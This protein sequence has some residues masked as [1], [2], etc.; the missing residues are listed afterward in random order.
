MSVESYFYPQPSLNRRRVAVPAVPLDVV[1][2]STPVAVPAV[3]AAAADQPGGG[4]RHGRGVGEGAGAAGARHH[5]HRP[6]QGGAAHTRAVNE[7]SR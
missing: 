3:P 5:R 1:S 4:A 2:K 7:H 6:R